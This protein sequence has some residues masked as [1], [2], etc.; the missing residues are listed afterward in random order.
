MSLI[1]KM[2]ASWYLALGCLS[3]TQYYLVKL[4]L[5]PLSQELTPSMT[6]Q[7]G[8]GMSL[9]PDRTATFNEDISVTNDWD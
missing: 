1:G 3:Q 2:L 6:G 7:S 9:E 4:L 5:L 8:M